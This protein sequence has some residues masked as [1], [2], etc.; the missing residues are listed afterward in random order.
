VRAVVVWTWDA[1]GPGASGCGV[2]DA[3]ESAMRAAE[4]GMRST[5]AAVATV[6]VMTHLGGGGWM[7]DGYRPTGVYWTARMGASGNVTWTVGNRRLAVA[8]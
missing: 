5:G 7:R 4:K 3:G 1:D 8:S 6:N 2:S